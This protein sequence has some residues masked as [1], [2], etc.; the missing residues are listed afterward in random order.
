MPDRKDISGRIAKELLRIRQQIAEIRAQEAASATVEEISRYGDHVESAEGQV[1]E[2]VIELGLANNELLQEIAEYRKREDE[3]RTHGSQVESQLKERI[4]ELELLYKELEHKA[5]DYLQTIEDLRLQV[6]ELSE[7][8]SKQSQEVDSH[9]ETNKRLAEEYRE[10]EKLM[11]QRIIEMEQ[12]NAELHKKEEMLLTEAD[13]KE[14]QTREKI[15]ELEKINRLVLE[16]AEDYKQRVQEL[17]KKA[18]HQET[19]MKE[20]VT[21]LK[22][23]NKD[24]QHE[25]TGHTHQPRLKQEPDE[26]IIETTLDGIILSWNPAAEKMCGYT[27][28]EVNGFPFSILIPRKLYDAFQ[29]TMDRVRQGG[30]DQRIN[31]VFVRKDGQQ[32]EVSLSTTRILDDKGKIIGA[33]VM[34]RQNL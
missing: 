4:V 23:V 17:L 5:A 31:T 20:R 11:D 19:S 16:E 32:V 1:R 27:A 33:A 8:V 10:F 34:V 3:L 28:G 14:N 15:S 29:K 21:H 24:L 12:E 22:K 9:R 13:L 6:A 30:E 26:A 7:Q 18:S 2:R 25:I